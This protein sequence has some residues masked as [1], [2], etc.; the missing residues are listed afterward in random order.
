MVSKKISSRKPK[1]RKRNASTKKSRKKSRKWS[2]IAPMKSSV[3]NRLYKKDPSCFLVPPMRGNSPKYPICNKHGKK[4]CKG[5]LS[6]KMRANL[7]SRTYRVST[8]TRKS[9]RKV[10]KKAT[11]IAKKHGCGV[12]KDIFKSR[13][14]KKSR[15]KSKKKSRKKSRKFS[16]RKVAGL[17]LG[18][19][20][21]TA[22]GIYGTRVRSRQNAI[23]YRKQTGYTPC[24]E[25]TF[26]GI[27]ATVEYDP[28]T[29]KDNTCNPN[30]YTE[31]L[32]TPWTGGSTFYQIK[33]PTRNNYDTSYLKVKKDHSRLYRLLG[34]N[35]SNP[36]TRQVS[37]AFREF[38]LENHPDRH[39]TNLK[40]E[41]T[42]K[43]A[44]VSDLWGEYKKDKKKQ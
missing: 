15:K 43:F 37:K 32:R 10:G 16:M 2:S 25:P 6:A 44:R 31:E 24:Y 29:G 39:P 5:V 13:K 20:L 36:S 35:Q 7:V 42:K 23:N 21:L 11:A 19:G 14:R 41:A 9:A 8:K 3:R 28:H 27:Q 17:V 40:K 38:S 30:S 33:K 34:I 1:I 26:D 22:G 12:M 18:A 4:L